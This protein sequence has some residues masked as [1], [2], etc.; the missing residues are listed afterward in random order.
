MADKIQ[1]YVVNEYVKVQLQ[2]LVRCGAGF[3]VAPPWAQ[4]PAAEQTLREVPGGK[5]DIK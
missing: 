4:L 2:S 3:C 1:D 5:W